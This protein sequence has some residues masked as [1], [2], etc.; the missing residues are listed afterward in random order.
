MLKR[1]SIIYWSQAGIK[2][3]GISFFS[4]VVGLLWALVVTMFMGVILGLYVTLSGQLSY[5]M[6]YALGICMLVGVF[7]G[8][9]VSGMH[10]SRYGWLHGSITA[11]LY[12]TLV[13]ILFLGSAPALLLNPGLWARF[14]LLITAG[15]SAGIIGVNVPVKKARLLKGIGKINM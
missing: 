4:V 3:G 6:P 13:L 15:I 5:Y 12:S 8:G 10:A 2:N 11:V 14:L 9:G 7:A 1:F